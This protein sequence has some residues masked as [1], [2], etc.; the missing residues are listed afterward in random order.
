MYKDLQHEI[1]MYLSNKVRMIQMETKTI[2][3][4]SDKVK[5][6]VCLLIKYL[7]YN[8]PDIITVE[9]DDGTLVFNFK[10]KFFGEGLEENLLKM[11]VLNSVTNYQNN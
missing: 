9:I 5:S 11:K 6:E 3:E 2:E 7:G 10:G 4:I 1:E 8:E